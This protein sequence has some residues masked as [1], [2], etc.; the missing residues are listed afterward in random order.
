MLT[1]LGALFP[2]FGLIA[3]GF[4]CARSGYLFS[5]ADD[6]LSQFVARITLP[7]LAFRVIAG[8]HASDLVMPAMVAAALGTPAIVWSAL[9]L[10]ERWR[11][12]DA[13][14][15]HVTAFGACFGNHAF[16]G[17]PVCLALIGPATM[18]PT[19][20][21]I[22][23]TSAFVF[24]WGVFMQVLT[25]QGRHT[26]ADGRGLVALRIVGRQLA[27]NPLVVL[28][29]AGVGWSALHLPLPGPVMALL[30]TLGNATGPCAL[31]AI[32]LFLARPLQEVA[33]SMAMR[34]VAAKLLAMPAVTWALLAL[35]PPLPPAWLATTLIMAGVPVGAGAFV[36]G[37]QAGPR[38]MQLGASLVVFS[39]AAAAFTLP[40]LIA[41][42]ER[43][44]IVQL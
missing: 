12:A 38:Q 4:A 11:G 41:G 16:V 22:A 26:L 15:A 17:L 8:S 14:S 25:Q 23:L 28:S 43:T 2:V 33:S 34:G 24:G 1:I 20:V 21:I 32:G 42:L 31:V 40:L 9:F 35:F 3:L 29:L 27:T 10:F 44:G 39:V 7:V 37:A 19:A 5:G 36:I 6:V 30:T 18:A 13:A